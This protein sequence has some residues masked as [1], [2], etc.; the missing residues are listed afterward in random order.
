LSISCRCVGT[1]VRDMSRIPLV[2]EMNPLL[3]RTRAA[4]G[5]VPNLYAALASS[6]AALGGYL[7]F[8]EALSEGTLPAELRERIALLVAA[9]NDC[10]YCV[11]A[12]TAR[13]RKLGLTHEELWATRRAESADA[14]TAA[15]LSFVRAVSAARGK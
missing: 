6:P 5:R 13:G 8:R 4:L 15:A 10:D 14:K 9:Q 7:G 1:H 3:E 11:A 2:T 12:H